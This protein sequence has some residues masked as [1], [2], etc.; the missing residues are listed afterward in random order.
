[1]EKMNKM[2]FLVMA[3]FV[4][5]MCLPFTSCSDDD[6]DVSVPEELIGTWSGSV[7]TSKTGTVREL[8]VTFHDD[9]TG[10]M[11]YSSSVYYRVAEFR[12]SVSG[13]IIT[14]K[15]VIAGEDGVANEFNQQFEFDGTSLTPIG[16]YDEFTLRR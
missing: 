11:Q 8:T 13:S 16:M 10:S 7:T 9:G 3:L 6:D 1:M 15:G 2:R 12:F 5:I 14:C 4:S